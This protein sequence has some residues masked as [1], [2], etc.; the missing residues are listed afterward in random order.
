MMYIFKEHY[1]IQRTRNIEIVM[2][3]INLEM[4]LIKEGMIKMQ[5]LKSFN[6][7]NHS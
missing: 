5:R 6:H 2:V 1:K 3:D 7:Y 4:H